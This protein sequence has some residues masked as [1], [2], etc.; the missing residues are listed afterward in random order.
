MSVDYFTSDKANSLLSLQDLVTEFTTESGIVRGIDGVSYDVKAGECLGVVGESGS[1]KS[2]TAMS[3]LG[4]LPSTARVTSGHAFF[5]GEDLIGCGERAM[6]SVR[7]RDI[8]MIF[9][10][11]MTALNPVLSIETQI[12]ET[13]RRHNP[14]MSRAARRDR[15]IELLNDVGIADAA[16]RVTQFPHQ[17]SG[18]MRQRVMIAIAVANRPELIIADEPTTALDVTIQAQILELLLTVQAKVGAALILITHDLAVIAEMADRVVV[19]LGGRVVEQA[20]VDAIFHDTKHPY[21][22][23]LLDSLPRIDERSDRLQ[24]LDDRPELPATGSFS[25]GGLHPVDSVARMLRV[26]LDHYVAQ[27]TDSSGGRAAW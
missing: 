17:F 18:G 19:M 13:L 21:T 23:S 7:G 1:G 9:Q 27:E 26:G 8:G 22:R 11:P 3:A 15:I 5:K 16:E 2:V 12:G 20:P 14:G 6:Q 4:L 24:A 10:D 25:L